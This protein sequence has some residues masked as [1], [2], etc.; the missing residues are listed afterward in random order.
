MFHF[1]NFFFFTCI[2]GVALIAY[3]A[4]VHV[5]VARRVR[6]YLHN[7]DGGENMSVL[8]VAL[9]MLEGSE[10]RPHR[11]FDV[12]FIL[13]HFININL[14]FNIGFWTFTRWIN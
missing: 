11:N 8:E 1:L 5:G 4:K 3:R 7:R 10:T 12:R 9:A 6:N 2:I 14:N 13:S